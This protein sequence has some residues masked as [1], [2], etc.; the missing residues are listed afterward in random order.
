MLTG[1]F[2]MA[3]LMHFATSIKVDLIVRKGSE[4]RQVEFARRQDAGGSIHGSCLF[5]TLGCATG[6]G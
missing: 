4:Y 2:A 6:R 3:Y 5:G 1:S